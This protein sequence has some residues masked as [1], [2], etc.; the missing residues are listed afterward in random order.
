M[1]PDPF[2]EVGGMTLQGL[3]GVRAR[4]EEFAAGVFAP[5]R[6]CRSAAVGGAVCAGVAE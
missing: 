3:E 2:V 4:L 1:C 5:F 6:A